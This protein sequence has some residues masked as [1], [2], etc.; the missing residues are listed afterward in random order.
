MI[1]KGVR[2]LRAGDVVAF[3]TETVYGLAV[4]AE[5]TEAVKK[6]YRIKGRDAKKPMALLVH[7]KAQAEKLCG[8]VPAPVKKLM[9]KFWPGPLTLVLPSRK[10]KSKTIGLRLPDHALSL[11]IARAFKK[12]IL[13]TSAN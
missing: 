8:P 5:N 3:A 2:L 12:P 9:K 13:L 1:K 7:S 4:A 6:L 11:A 10:D